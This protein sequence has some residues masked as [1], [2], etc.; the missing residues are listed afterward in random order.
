MSNVKPYLTRKDQI[1]IFNLLLMA[2]C[3]QKMAIKF[4]DVYEMNLD[5]VN[6]YDFNPDTCTLKKNVSNVPVYYQ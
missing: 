4:F 1:K 5:E 6:E 2:S 3:N